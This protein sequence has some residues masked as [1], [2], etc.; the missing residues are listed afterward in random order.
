M[1]TYPFELLAQRYHWLP[2]HISTAVNVKNTG[3]RPL[4]IVA[5]PR[6]VPIPLPRIALGPTRLNLDIPI[7]KNRSGPEELT[8]IHGG[9]LQHIWNNEETDHAPSDVDLIKL[10]HTAIPSS[11]CDIF[12]RDVEI[13]FRCKK[14][15]SVKKQC[16]GDEPPSASFPR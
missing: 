9:I 6:A 2:R 3:N 13:I 16:Q 10:G 4:I 15:V 8:G 7:S 11:H 5:R 12:Q 1:I 14:D